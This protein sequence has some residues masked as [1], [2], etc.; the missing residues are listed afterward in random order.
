MTVEKYA[1]LAL[2][3]ACCTP[4]A[5]ADKLDSEAEAAALIFK[6]LSDPGRVRIL[7]LI[8]TAGESVCVCDL[9]SNLELSQPTTSF[10]LKKLVA[11]GLLF[12]E[13]RGTWAYYSINK[14]ALN[15]VKRIFDT[16][17]I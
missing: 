6:A 15:Q 12:R 16:K 17:G 3:V 10:H 2:P 4:I 1:E 13:Q 14:K 5:D 11:A 8:A 7:N 9:T